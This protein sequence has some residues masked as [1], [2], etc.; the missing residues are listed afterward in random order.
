MN[1]VNLG[2][3][4]IARLKHC[5]KGSIPRYGVTNLNGN[6]QAL[7]DRLYCLCGDRENRSMFP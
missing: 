7:Y 2:S 1:T 5:R 6:A 4:F 3:R